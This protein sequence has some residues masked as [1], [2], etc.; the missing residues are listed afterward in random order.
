MKG[1]IT[2]DIE[3]QTSDTLGQMDAYYV[4]QNIHFIKQSL[5]K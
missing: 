2:D 3:G 4:R 1:D 5:Q